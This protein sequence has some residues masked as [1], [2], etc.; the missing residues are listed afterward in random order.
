MWIYYA[1]PIVL[2][3]V[4]LGF[5]AFAS[6]HMLAKAANMSPEEVA[7][8]FR[9]YYSPFFEIPPGEQLR[10]VWNGVAFM[11]PK[12]LEQKVGAAA[13]ELALNVVG[14]SRY[15]PSVYVGLTESGKV[16]VSTEYSDMGERGNFKQVLALAAGTRAVDATSAYPGENIGKAPDNPFNPGVDL[17]FTRLHAPNGEGFDAWLSPQGIVLG[18]GDFEPIQQHLG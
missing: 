17:E 10:A 1:V 12:S 11:A 7:A 13:G 2:V 8:Q 18:A 5:S 16:L 14:V 15:I 3:I 9:S 4:A 6:K